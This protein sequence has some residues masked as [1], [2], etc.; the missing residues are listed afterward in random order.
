MLVTLSGIVIFVSRLQP[1]N[2][3]F[4]MLVTLSGIVIFVSWLQ[5][6]N[7]EFPMLVTLS[8][9]VIFVSR[10]QP[11]N[12]SSPMLVTLSG[13]VIFVSWLQLWNTASPM[14]VTSTSSLPLFHL[15][16]SLISLTSENQLCALKSDAIIVT[17]PSTTQMSFAVGT[18]SCQ[19]VSLSFLYKKLNQLTLFV[20]IKILSCIFKIALLSASCY[21][22]V[23]Y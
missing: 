2:A 11:W 16:G 10:L 5:T 9:I 12:A 20:F 21:S 23:S 8:G 4:P 15:L 6:Q 18:Y 3:E 13:I 22:S 7:I 1:Q 19:S 14:L 17:F